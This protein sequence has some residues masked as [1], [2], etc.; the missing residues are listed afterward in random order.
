MKMSSP[1]LLNGHPTLPCPGGA[2]SNA[3][4][5]HCMVCLNH[6]WGWLPAYLEMGIEA[7]FLLLAVVGAKGMLANGCVP[8]GMR[9][10]NDEGMS[11]VAILIGHGYVSEERVERKHRGGGTTSYLALIAT[12]LG[13]DAVRRMNRW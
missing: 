12:D 11:A 9:G 3:H 2:H 13:R 1:I 5:D 6:T 7:R 4:I 10:S 8:D